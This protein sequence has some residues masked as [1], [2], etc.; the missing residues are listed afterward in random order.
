MTTRHLT[1]EEAQ[2]HIEGLLTRTDASRVD[3]HLVGCGECQALV[4]S[5]RALEEALSCLPVAEPPADFT[6]GVLARIEAREQAAVRERRVAT[7]VLGSVAVALAAT[8]SIAG[9]AAWAP[10]L[11]QVSSAVADGAQALRISGD[12]LSPVVGA[13]RLQILV[14]CAAIGLPLLLGLARLVPGRSGQ[15]A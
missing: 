2:L 3:G 14:A 6:A 13:L 10:A 9:Q 11:S 4:L 15:I 7:A 12:V 8:L 1:E 5:F